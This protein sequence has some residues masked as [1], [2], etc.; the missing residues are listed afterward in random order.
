MI[1]FPSRKDVERIKAE[2]PK[3]TRV[4]LIQM[5][6]PQAPA[7]GTEGT[8]IRVDDVGTIHVKWDNG[9]MLGAVLDVDRVSKT[10]RRENDENR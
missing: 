3:G 10:Q 6:D 7:P 5:N 8:V 9:S 4:I 1:R 2:Y